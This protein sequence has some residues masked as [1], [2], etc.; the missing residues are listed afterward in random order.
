MVIGVVTAATVSSS[1]I[2]QQ[3]HRNI[4]VV[5]VIITIMPCTTKTKRIIESRGPEK[6]H[7]PNV[8]TTKT[9]P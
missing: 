9:H 3:Q 1:L 5:S 4:I 7:E 2:Q 6:V 8:C